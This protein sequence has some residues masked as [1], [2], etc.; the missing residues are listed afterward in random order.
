MNAFACVRLTST[1]T[2]R[3]ELFRWHIAT[4]FDFFFAAKETLPAIATEIAKP[5]TKS[6]S[7]AAL[8]FKSFH[9]LECGF[10]NACPCPERDKRLRL[11]H[12]LDFTFGRAQAPFELQDLAERLDRHLELVERRLARRQ[13]L[14]PEAGREQRHQRAVTGV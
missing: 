2:G 5:T 8:I 6:A 1:V 7:R 10:R 12:Y 9:P 11:G 14:Q 13:A 4:N 3:F